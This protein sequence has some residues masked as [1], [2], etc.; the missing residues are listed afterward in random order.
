MKWRKKEVDRPWKIPHL[1]VSYI[2]LQLDGLGELRSFS[3]KL[4]FTCFA[5]NLY[6]FVRSLVHSLLW[7]LWLQF[8]LNDDPPARAQ[9]RHRRFRFSR[10][11]CSSFASRQFLIP[12]FSYRS[13]SVAFHNSQHASRNSKVTSASR[14]LPFSLY[15]PHNATHFISD[16][17]CNMSWIVVLLRETNRHARP[18][19]EFVA[20]NFD[21]NGLLILFFFLI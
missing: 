12:S 9:W 18:P 19:I 10:L 3:V 14:L 2:R 6:L 4:A 13:I 21:F 8:E 17:V 7:R 11:C 5:L 16:F 20:K 15:S 1:S